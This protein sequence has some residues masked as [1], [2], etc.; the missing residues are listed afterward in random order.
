MASGSRSAAPSGHIDPDYRVIIALREVTLR[1]NLVGAEF[2]A[3]HHLHTTDLRAI[4]ELLDAERMGHTATP[5][6]LAG[7]LR[8]NSASVT[9][10]VDRLERMGHVQRA[11][12]AADRR[13]VQL[14]VTDNAR[15]LGETFFGPLI[16][17]IV[18]IMD[19]FDAPERDAIT[20]FLAAVAAA[21]PD[22]PA[23]QDDGSAS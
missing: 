15:R 21:V 3:D 20:R 6:W 1:L 18:A 22:G 9:A 17:R 10:L 23:G 5:T 4:I 11:R 19:S 14:T 13:R 12:A 8:L 16:G 7:R 2:A